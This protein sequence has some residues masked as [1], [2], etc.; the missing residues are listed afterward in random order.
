MLLYDG[1]LW[2][3]DM[4]RKESIGRYEIRHLE[5]SGLVIRD[6]RIGSRL[7]IGSNSSRGS[8]RLIDTS[9]L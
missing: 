3:S 8:P 5:R 7:S 1:C 6:L 2:R 4:L 9:T